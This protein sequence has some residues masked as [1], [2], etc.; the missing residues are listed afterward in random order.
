MKDWLLVILI[1]IVIAVCA[2][3]LNT[4]INDLKTDMRAVQ[5]ELNSTICMRFF[6]DSKDN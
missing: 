2:T 1:L 3:G 4:R 5:E 6:D